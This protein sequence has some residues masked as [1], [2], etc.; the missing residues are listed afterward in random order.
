MKFVLKSFIII[1]LSLLASG[2]ITVSVF[3]Q[4]GE[5]GLLTGLGFVVILLVLLLTS[6]VGLIRGRIAFLRIKGR[7]GAFWLGLASILFMVYAAGVV[8]VNIILVEELLGQG[9]GAREKAAFLYSQ[10]SPD[11]YAE[12]LIATEYKEMTIHYPAGDEETVKKIKQLY[13]KAKEKADIVFGSGTADA[14]KVIVYNSRDAM[15]ASSGNPDFGGFYSPDDKSLHVLSTAVKNGWGFE[16]TF[17]HEYAHFRMFEYIERYDVNIRTIPQWFTEGVA[18]VVALWDIMRDLPAGEEADLSRLDSS[19]DFHAARKEGIDTYV[20][21]CFAVQELVYSHGETVITAILEAAGGQEFEKAFENVHGKT[22]N[23]FQSDYLD[24]VRQISNLMNEYYE[25][26]GQKK[27]KRAEEV[28]TEMQ[29]LAPQHPFAAGELPLIY[30]KQ[31]KFEQAVEQMEENIKSVD[32][33]YAHEFNMLAELYLLFDPEQALE[34]AQRAKGLT[35]NT[36]GKNHH[37]TN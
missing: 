14:F 9:T 4:N 8:I 27:F 25:E 15:D 26:R 33:P 1:L 20:Q 16:K 5:W 35:K 19:M 6:L 24:R 30:I 34:Y 17:F 37:R 7:W 13:P 36:G 11:A 32:G 21:S 3:S 31:K 2:M 18:E 10:L 23:D 12:T 22:L 29:G 28:L